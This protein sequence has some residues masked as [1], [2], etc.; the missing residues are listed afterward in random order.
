MGLVVWRCPVCGG[1]LGVVLVDAPN[2]GWG[3]YLR[4]DGCGYEEAP[5]PP[6]DKP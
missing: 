3:S 4:C 5:N 2:G 6:E 1:P